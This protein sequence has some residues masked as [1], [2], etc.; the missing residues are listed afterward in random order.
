MRHGL[1]LD[2]RF[3]DVPAQTVRDHSIRH[4][5]GRKTGDG[6]WPSPISIPGLTPEQTASFT[7]GLEDGKGGSLTQTFA[8]TVVPPIPRH[9]QVSSSKTPMATVSRTTPK[10]VFPTR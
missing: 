10:Q 5:D 1:L 3:D 6:G 9:S 2:Y 4:N 7:I 8:V